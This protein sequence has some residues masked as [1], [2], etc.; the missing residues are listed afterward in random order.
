MRGWSFKWCSGAQK[1]ACSE[2]FWWLVQE[3]SKVDQLVETVEPEILGE[4][5][6]TP[7]NHVH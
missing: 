5:S 3:F 1:E 6:D 4:I 7:C 2:T